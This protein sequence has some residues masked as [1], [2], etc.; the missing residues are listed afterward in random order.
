MASSSSS[1]HPGKSFST[2]SEPARAVRDCA[3][4]AL[5]PPSDRFID[6]HDNGSLGADPMWSPR[7]LRS[8]RLASSSGAEQEVMSS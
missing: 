5:L 1:K 4:G 2:P 7:A 6:S 8:A 3:S